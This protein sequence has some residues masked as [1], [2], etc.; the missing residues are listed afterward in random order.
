MSEWTLPAEKGERFSQLIH[1]LEHNGDIEKLRPFLRGGTWRNFQSLYDESN[2]MQKR[3][4]QASNRLEAC[5]MEEGTSDQLAEI[6]D[7]L[8]RAQCN[9]AYWH[10]VFGGLYLPHLRHAIYHHLLKT[11]IGMD[12][13]TKPQVGAVMDIDLDGGKEFIL[14]SETLKLIV[15]E[16]GGIIRELDYLPAKFNLVNTMRRYAESYHA[17][18]KKAKAPSNNGGS[19][20]DLVLAKEDGLEKFL[21]VDSTPRAILVDHFLSLST[22]LEEI[23]KNIPEQGN[24]YKTFFQGEN[25]NDIRLS[26]DGNAFHQAISVL[27]QI[28]L[29]EDT[30]SV[31]IKLENRSSD[32]LAGVYANELNFSLLGGHA[33]DR[34]YVM[35]DQ[36]PEDA[37]LDTAAENHDI[38]SIGIVNEWDQFKT[39]VFFEMPTAVWRY[40]VFTVSMSEAGFEKVY[41]SS[42][43]TPHWQ[44]NLA[45]KESMTIGMK[46]KV[47]E[48]NKNTTK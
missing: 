36:K 9:C 4:V 2:W 1:S 26:A 27:K 43:I 37:F 7:D 21:Q 6:R 38:S 34:Y 41:Q 15:S 31:E 22:T 30:V 44:L 13:L 10:G 39:T 24:L 17:K 29:K 47:E 28:T 16:S 19:I 32:T 12:R 45:P 20:H 48:W 40:P 18:V 35:N 8:W 33:P 5:L 23:Q 3:M 42:V 11:E 14:Q 25:G 46:I